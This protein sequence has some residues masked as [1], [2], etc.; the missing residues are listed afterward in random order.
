MPK[1]A[2]SY[3]LERIYFEKLRSDIDVAKSYIDAG[4]TG[5]AL[6]TLRGLVDVDG[7]VLLL[8]RNLGEIWA[9][10]AAQIQKTKEA[11]DDLIKTVDDYHKELNEKIDEV[12]NYLIRLINALED[13]VIALEAETKV[14][15][16]SLIYDSTGDEYSIEIDGETL[17]FS[18]AAALVNY[19]HLLILVDEAGNYYY[20]RKTETGAIEWE[21]STIDNGDYTENVI[22]FDASGVTKA[23]N[24]IVIPEYTAGTGIDIT[25]YEIS[26]D[27][28]VIQEKLTAGNG[29]DIDSN[30]EISVDTDV[31]QEKLTAGQNIQIS[32]QN[33][34]SATDT[35]YSA[36]TGIDIDNSNVISADF[37]EV[38][39]KLTAGSG[40]AIDPV[41]NEVSNT[42]Q[43]SILFPA[44]PIS[45]IDRISAISIT[46][47]NSPHIDETI[48]NIQRRTSGSQK[49][50]SLPLNSQ[51]KI[52]GIGIT[53]SYDSV[54]N[55]SYQ[56][57]LLIFTD[58]FIDFTVRGTKDGNTVS[59]PCIVNLRNVG[60]IFGSSATGGA[61]LVKQDSNINYFDLSGF[62]TITSITPTRI[63]MFVNVGEY[64][65]PA[66]FP[67]WLIQIL[68][69][70]VIFYKIV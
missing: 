23:E 52:K 4:A 27:T 36:G 26:V 60:K 10:L 8:Y 19:P 45:E 47:F 69:G 16:A 9:D 51:E 68:A 20:P 35:T 31:I 46:Y 49:G 14:K 2:D 62:D 64:Q 65:I 13:R 28:D 30:N 61:S 38:Q 54:M 32:A 3:R 37:N 18:E 56:N 57:D 39:A 58:V 12:N 44:G 34:I 6:D 11:L 17:T 21:N 53:F 40:I 43:G 1:F 29:I 5:E 67:G 55:F 50:V 63:D 66:S 48:N 33:V 70:S 25:G 15:Y 22:T 42:A 59:L 7:A 41:T 24:T